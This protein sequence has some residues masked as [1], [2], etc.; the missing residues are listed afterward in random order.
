MS[1]K[2]VI[3]TPLIINNDL[4][5]G[6]NITTTGDITANFSNLTTNVFTGTNIYALNSNINNGTIDYL[7]FLAFTGTNA[8]IDDLRL[9]NTQIHLGTESGLTS[10]GSNTVAIGNLAGRQNQGE[11]SVSIGYYSGNVNQGPQ[12]V[13]IGNSAGFDRQSQRAI[14]IGIGAG[15]RLQGEYSIAIGSNSGNQYQ[16][17]YSI[18]LG[19]LAGANNAAANSII[20]NANATQLNPTTN[21]FFVNPIRNTNSSQFLQYDTTTN[22]ITYANTGTL[23]TLFTNNLISSSSV[24]TIATTQSYIT[25]LGVTG[26]NMA[27][28]FSFTF[29]GTAAAN[30]VYFTLTFSSPFSGNKNPIVVISPVNSDA[31]S[32]IQ[33]TYYLTSSISSFSMLCGA[34]P[35]ST[36]KRDCLFNYYVMGVNN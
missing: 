26:T 12:A 36:T 34:T 27:G 10:Q 23:N 25:N 8:S 20:L 19:Y 6:G 3:N 4:N 18:A 17:A 5:I 35:P 24:P 32:F 11:N 30:N 33:S 28:T 2:Y 15:Y 31:G 29:Q 13:S 16:G 21:G 14:A 7:N 1:S 22:E 9:N